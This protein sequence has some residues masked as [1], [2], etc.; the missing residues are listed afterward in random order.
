MRF[1]DSSGD[2]HTWTA[3]TALISPK[4]T[5]MVA[6]PHAQ[7]ESPPGATDSVNVDMSAENEKSVAGQGDNSLPRG[8]S[9]CN[10]TYGLRL[11]L[12]VCMFGL[13]SQCRFF[14]PRDLDSDGRQA[15]RRP[16]RPGLL[17]LNVTFCAST[18]LHLHQRVRDRLIWQERWGRD[19]R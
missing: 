10:G 18:F 4:S 16:V 12:Q 9:S 17:K 3:R 14:T 7:G 5:L 6:M 19:D 2:H 1:A 11:D 8:D 15:H 13:Q